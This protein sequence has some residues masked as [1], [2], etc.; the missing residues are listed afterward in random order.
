MSDKPV[1]TVTDIY[2]Q[3]MDH[4]PKMVELETPFNKECILS[5]MK[6]IL[7]LNRGYENIAF[8]NTCIFKHELIDEI[9]L[10]CKV[11]L[12]TQ[13]KFYEQLLCNIF[14]LTGLTRQKYDCPNMYVYSKKALSYIKISLHC[15]TI[16]ETTFGSLM[17]GDQ[18]KYIIVTS[19]EPAHQQIIDDVPDSDCAELY[20][21]IH[22]FNYDDSVK[23][24]L[25]QRWSFIEWDEG[26]RLFYEHEYT[27]ASIISIFS[28][29][30]VEPSPLIKP[31]DLVLYISHIM[32]IVCLPNLVRCSQRNYTNYNQCIYNTSSELDD[33]FD[34]A[35][36]HIKNH[37]P[38]YISK[39]NEYNAKATT[40]ENY[41][42]LKNNNTMLLDRM[43]ILNGEY[44]TLYAK[45]Q[46]LE[47]EHDKLKDK[48]KKLIDY[49]YTITKMFD[50][51]Y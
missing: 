7:A 31:I 29:N 16:S 9:I 10:R 8:E 40:S 12:A 18:Y 3:F 50:F 39:I 37:H 14:Y 25:L 45:Y 46:L 28:G 43:K 15:N 4:Y 22:L 23:N 35:V 48:V 33:V 6:D 1:V 27:K 36:T 2:N 13:D 21:D 49:S 26:Y 5:I 20:K 44:N 34:F 11:F 19:T 42:K 41:Y 24:N 51:T 17:D 30:C 47:Q 32:D 38:Q